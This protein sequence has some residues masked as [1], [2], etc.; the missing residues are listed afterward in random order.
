DPPDLTWEDIIYHVISE[1]GL[2]K[3]TTAVKI[4]AAKGN[5]KTLF[6]YDLL[7][8]ARSYTHRLYGKSEQGFAL[9]AY[10]EKRQT[11]LAGYKTLNYLYYL[12]AG[13]WAKENGADEALIRNP[14]G[15]ISETNTA[16]I[17]VI[18]GRRVIKPVSPHA[19][20]GIMEDA[21]CALLS[22]M[23]YLMEKRKI[24]PGEILSA[25]GVILTNSLMGA[26][27]AVRL[28]GKE[29]A[30]SSKLCTK[31]NMELF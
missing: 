23:E 4:I 6:N 22:G 20:P 11:P 15:S 14:D 18:K 3:E 12:L 2:D 13:R 29:L 7:V 8:T 17:L 24:F 27:P 19:L 21:V 30:D 5:G 1:N 9:A 28:D 26:V 31:V 10:P 25:D 16:N